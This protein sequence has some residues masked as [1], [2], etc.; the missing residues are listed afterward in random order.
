METNPE[1]VTV[2]FRELGENGTLRLRHDGGTEPVLVVQCDIRRGRPPEQRTRL[3]E[4]VAGLLRDELEWPPARTILEFTEHAGDEVW[5][6]GDWARTG[7]RGMQ[8]ERG[9]PW[10]R[11]VRHRVRLVTLWARS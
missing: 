10:R 6:Q 11:Q 1:R 8:D 5:R 7:R 3:G 2:A 4:A 9:A